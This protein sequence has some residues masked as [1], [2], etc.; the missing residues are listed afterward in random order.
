MAVD[1]FTGWLKRFDEDNNGRISRDELAAA[2]RAWG[3]W[4]A[5]RKSKQGIRSV[6]ANEIKKPRTVCRAT[7][8]C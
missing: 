7:L 5:N 8:E 4:F 2:I 3:R 1:E 6:D